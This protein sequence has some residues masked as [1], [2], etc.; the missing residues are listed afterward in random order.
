MSK[1]PLLI[2]GYNRPKK[3]KNLLSIVITNP[4]ISKIYIKIDGPRNYKDIEEILLIKKLIKNFKK[5]KSQIIAKFEKKNLGLQKNII[6]AI[7]WVFLKEKDLIILEDDNVPSKDFF[8]FCSKMLDTYKNSKKIMHISGTN[9][10]KSFNKDDYYF[11][12]MPDI[13]GWATWKNKWNK[14]V[15]KFDLRL[16][17]KNNVVKK[18][19]E[20]DER[21]CHWFYEYLYREVNSEKNHNLWSTWWQL[22]IISNDALSINPGKNLVYHDGYLKSDNPAHINEK[23]VAKNLRLQNIK[24]KNFSIRK[25]IY[26]HKFDIPHYKI[27]KETD[28]HFT[29]YNL[30]RWQLKFNLRK[31]RNDFGIA[32]LK[33]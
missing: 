32:Y 8:N 27:I 12:K 7:N 28:P 9:F 19:Y 3:I 29:N 21:I 14:L 17:I 20:F 4:S 25:I 2:I 13:V 5:K 24:T 15:N 11:S 6:S 22:T 1:K 31:L 18:Y 10:N 16:I 26:Q 33:I 30:L 23:A